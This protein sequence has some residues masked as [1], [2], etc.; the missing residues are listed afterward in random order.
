MVARVVVSQPLPL[1]PLVARVVLPPVVSP[2]LPAELLVRVPPLPVPRSLLTIP[3]IL[4]VVV[5]VELPLF[6]L[7][8]LAGR[9]A[10]VPTVVGEAAEEHPVPL[11]VLVPQ[12]QH[13]SS[14]AKVATDSSS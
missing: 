10:L 13:P 1:Q 5:V 11:A 12:P 9:V 8:I 4:A 3:T 6:S 7:L 2:S 14:A